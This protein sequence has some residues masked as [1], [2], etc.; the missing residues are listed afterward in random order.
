MVFAQ[1]GRESKLFPQERARGRLYYI[2][3]SVYGSFRDHSDYS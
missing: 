3:L 2:E 1:S